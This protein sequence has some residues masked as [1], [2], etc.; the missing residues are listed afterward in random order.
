MAKL[1]KLVVDE[2]LKKNCESFLKGINSQMRYQSNLSGDSTSFEWVDTIEFVCPYIDNIVRNPRVALINEEDVVKIERAK[3]ISVDS[4]KDLSKHTHYI[5]KINEETNEVQPSKIL[6]T[7]REET[8]NTYENRFIY[9]LITNLSRFMITKEA[10]LEDFETKNDKVL[11]YAGSTSNNI[12]R[13]NIELKVTSYSIP[14]GSGADDFAKELEEIRKRVK[15][16]RDYIS[17]WRRSE[18]YSSLEE[19]RVPF[20]VPPI[21]KT[22]LILKNPNFQNATKLWEF[23]QTYDFNE[24]E[25]TSK[26]G[27]DTTGNDIM[28]AILDEAFLMD[29]FVLAS[30]SPSKREQKE[31]LI[32]Y[33]MTS[34]NL[35]IKRVVSILLDYG[36]DISEKE[37]LNMISI[38]I[39]EEKNRRLASTKD[40]RDKFKTAL[41][42][43]LEKMQEYM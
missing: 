26:E 27:L 21:R 4:V 10:F 33:V 29:Y 18:M 40:V 37:L 36:I 19:A 13:I 32:K 41:E 8:Y 43:Y 20:V 22:N 6:I 15:R 3:K 7:R 16:I 42:E 24:F 38:E 35:H 2:K 5:E 12:E 31:K 11:E 17:S 9:T 23:L 30:I 14:E 39:N 34:L 28:K 25:D 1:S